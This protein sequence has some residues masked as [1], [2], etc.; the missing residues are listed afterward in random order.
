MTSITFSGKVVDPGLDSGSWY[1][2][3]AN[4]DPLTLRGMLERSGA[5][6]SDK[7]EVSI[8]IVEKRNTNESEHPVP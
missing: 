7:V 1:V 2:R 8:H 5:E 4:S 6:G 3:D